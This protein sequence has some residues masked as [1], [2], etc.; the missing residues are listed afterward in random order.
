M[1]SLFSP[2]LILLLKW[3]VLLALGWTAHWLLRKRHCCWRL[4]LW[5]SILCFSL[6]VP[7][8][9]FGPVPV[10]RIPIYETFVFPT[11]V[12]DVLPPAT[13][14]SPIPK[15][16]STVQSPVKLVEANTVAKSLN[17]PPAQT[18]SKAVRWGR[19]LVMIWGLGAG[20]AGLRLGRFQVQLNRLRKESRLA[21]PVLQG[22]VRE[23]QTKL[24]VQRTIGIRVSDSVSSPFA[25]GLLQPM[26]LLPKKLV[27]DLPPDEIAA[28]LAHEIAHFL[29]HDLFWN[30]GWRWMQAMFWF[31]P[32]VWKIPVAH[33]V[34][35]EQEA[36]R[37]A[38]RRGAALVRQ[39]FAQNV[40][41]PGLAE[42]FDQL[43][44]GRR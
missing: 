44:T 35:C 30:V 12:S 9:Q 29:R 16:K 32:L 13:G 7:L 19:L 1:N 11:E 39:H 20:F 31:H 10:F 25:C 4:I 18:A 33:N 37:T 5:R 8:M 28:L 2:A 43:V 3:T 27:Q 26:I 36:D 24:R 21:S 40:T 6:A 42:L 38:A 17:P 15:D 41:L 34:A 14:E 23:I 22:L